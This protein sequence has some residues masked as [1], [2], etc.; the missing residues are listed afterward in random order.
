MKLLAA[1]DFSDVTDNVVATLRQLAGDSAASVVLLHVMPEEKQDI[2]FHPTIDPHYHPP[3]KY[4]REPDSSEEG[5]AVPILHNKTSRR[6]RASQ[7]H[8]A[9]RA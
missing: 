4:Y 2:E 1:L 8:S 5:D 9:R 3:E 6:W 7:R